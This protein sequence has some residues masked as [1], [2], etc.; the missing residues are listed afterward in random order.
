MKIQKQDC[1]RRGRHALPLAV[2]TAMLAG[3][4]ATPVALADHGLPHLEV[5]GFGTFPEDVS[6]T[7][8]LKGLDGGTQV[9]K[10]QDAS[11]MFVISVTIESGGIAPWHT[12]DGTGV[13]INLGPGIVTNVVGDNCEPRYYLPHEAF[14]DP[15]DGELHAVR[16][17]SGEEVELLIVFFGVQDL[18]PVISTGGVGPEG[19]EFLP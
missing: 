17:D 2:M 6:A 18:T 15:G 9:L 1:R 12:H 19:C 16:N 5:L 7:F 11:D 13:L 4:A 14:I 3:M 8:K 10:L